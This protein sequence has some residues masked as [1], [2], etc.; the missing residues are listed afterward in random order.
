MMDT[1]SATAKR[2]CRPFGDQVQTALLVGGKLHVQY[3]TILPARAGTGSGTV[4]SQ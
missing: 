4:R 2:K 3:L 1:V